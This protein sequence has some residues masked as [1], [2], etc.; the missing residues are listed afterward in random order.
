MVAKNVLLEPFWQ[1]GGG[2]N[3]SVRRVKGMT[4]TARDSSET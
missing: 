3:Y 1:S 2:E 4:A